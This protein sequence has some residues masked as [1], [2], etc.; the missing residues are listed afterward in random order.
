VLF[1]LAAKWSF[2][3]RDRLSR[4]AEAIESASLRDR[5]HILEAERIDRLRASGAADLY[6]ICRELVDALNSKLT[7]PAVVLD[8][9]VYSRE[10]FEDGGANL[11]QIN[12]RGRLLQ[13][14]FASTDELISTEDFRSPYILNGSVRSYNQELLD[15]QAMEEH[16]IFYCL[17]GEAGRWYF[18]DCRAYRNGKL[19][20]DFLARGL[21]RLL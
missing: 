8:P 15:R 14:G 19:T 1:G 21:E 2:H 16:N 9:P 3:R 6:G 18:S 17:E 7:D 4:L 11:F 10:N 20:S 12:L 5:Q 13:I